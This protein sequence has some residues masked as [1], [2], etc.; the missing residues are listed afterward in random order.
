MSSY[1]F[2]TV[3][4]AGFSNSSSGSG[5]M[6]SGGSASAP[7]ST[8]TGAGLSLTPGGI[9]LEPEQM[10]IP[11]VG[12]EEARTE[13]E[14]LFQRDLESTRDLVDSLGFTTLTEPSISDPLNEGFLS[15]DMRQAYQEQQERED[16]RVEAVLNELVSN[17]AGNKEEGILTLGQRDS[18]ERMP[19]FEQREAWFKRNFPEGSLFRV[20]T[21][22]DGDLVELYRTHPQ[23]KAF[24]VSNDVFSFG[25]LGAV[26]SFANFT[27][28]GSVLGT[29]FGPIKGTAAGAY[30]GATIDEY[31]ANAMARGEFF[32]YSDQEQFTTDL[33][34]GNRLATSVVD[35]L[36]TKFLPMMGRS[37][38]YLG[39]KAL[40]LDERGGS[41]LYEL[42]FFS[43]SPKAEAAQKAAVQLSEELGVELPLFNMSQ[44]S[45]SVLLRGMAQQATGTSK[46]LPSALS[47]QEARL[48][49]ALQKKKAEMGGDF[50]K[51]SPAEL[52]NYINLS[53]KSLA[54]S[55]HLRY[56]AN[57]EGNYGLQSS[58]VYA[59]EIM[60]K[61]KELDGGLARAI[62]SK[63]QEA[64]SLAGIDNVTF[65]LSP[66]L[67]VADEIEQGLLM[68]ARPSAGRTASGQPLKGT[69]K[70]EQKVFAG[71]EAVRSQPLG[72]DLQRLISD[73]K[74][75]IDPTLK[76]VK[77]GTAIKGAKGVT[78]LKNVDAFQQ[79]K[80]IRDRVGNLIQDSSDPLAKSNALKLRDSIDDLIV[81]GY[82][83]G[84][85]KGGSDAW[86]K[87]FN[88]AGELV[89]VRSQ[90]KTY[91]SL[92]KLLGD[93]ARTLPQT[94]ADELLEGGINAEQF[95]I[96]RNLSRTTALNETEK[97]AGRTM[98]QDVKEFALAS[99]IK[100][101]TSALKR[102]ETLKAVDEG[103]L[104]NELF[105]S[106]SAERIVMEEL[107]TGAAAISTDAVQKVLEGF[108]NKA[109]LMEYTR[110]IKS[111]RKDLAV[112]KFI[113]LNG[114][115]NGKAAMQI[116]AGILE[117]I[118][119]NST[120][121]QQTPGR[122]FAQNVI[123]ADALSQN[124]RNLRAQILNNESG[125]YTA[126]KG[127]F[128]KVQEDGSVKFSTEGKKYF[129]LI[130]NA[131][132]YAAFLTNSADIGGPFATGAIRSGVTSA[133]LDTTLRAFKSLYTNNILSKIFAAQPSVESL[134]RAMASNKGS[135][136]RRTAMAVTLLNQFIDKLDVDIDED[137][138][139]SV[140]QPII[141]R[142]SNVG[143]ET[144]RQEEKRTK[145]PPLMGT[146][147]LSSL[148]IPPLP[149]ASAPAGKSSAP[150]QSLFPRDELGGAIASRQGIMGLA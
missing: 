7:I 14:M 127:V 59:K 150:F 23:G 87:A 66:L 44:L 136:M 47:K 110:N 61:A 100:D 138:P 139:M 56:R 50:D 24:R 13:A 12:D 73:L 124:L 65:N 32:G 108:S 99:L 39:K 80:A 67:K 8:V 58:D 42:G 30:L 94:V 41:L 120:K 146:G 84:L 6:P 131:D 92:S 53:H 57:V 62:D 46:V 104:Y 37:G 21:S 49:E 27:T 111:N 88:E 82:E 98:L 112:G 70:G 3:T 69:G 48:L 34:S 107:E 135:Q 93:K 45:D 102:I 143:Q 85:V 10:E 63:Y 55:L 29:F 128:G 2:S 26:T 71:E 126:L 116:R 144:P 9:S 125:E 19:R 105:P 11:E 76:T 5:Q 149:L 132:L 54:D 140:I 16:T 20:K 90:A 43:V 75:V 114:G 40:D 119:S 1:K 91:A 86:R 25:D 81:N 147:Q 142:S 113:D 17:Y 79:L 77:E 31:I 64:F 103:R 83:K 133:K 33:L 109:A 134:Q 106:G 89:K 97:Q 95:R 28:V 130:T 121:K 123:D 68:T 118:L 72:G 117:E 52:S 51:F 4:G 129:D 115:Q 145:Q 148:D 36:L 101:P 15:P 18:L 96:L 137:N 78:A 141:D 60:E 122:E 38:Q 74:N 22:T 35:G